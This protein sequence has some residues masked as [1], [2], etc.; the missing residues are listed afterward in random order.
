MTNMNYLFSI[1]QNDLTLSYYIGTGGFIVLLIILFA[2][3]CY[4]KKSIT[5]KFPEHFFMQ[6]GYL[7]S[8]IPALKKIVSTTK[9]IVYIDFSSVQGMTEGSYMTLLAQVEK[10]YM[11][12]ANKTIRISLNLPRSKEV[13]NILVKQKKYKHTNIKLTSDVI[14]KA[15]NK[16]KLTSADI[17]HAEVNQIID[18]DYADATVLELKSIGIKDYY[19][20]FYDFLIEVIGNASEHGLLNKNINWWMLKYKDQSRKCMTYVFVDMGLGI[21]ESYRRSGLL[22]RYSLRDKKKIPLD[23]L[24][25]K[26]G[27]STKKDG[28]GRGLPQIREAVE[29]GIVSDF[30]LI[31]NSVSLHY[32][33]SKFVVTTNPNFIGTYFSWTINKENYLTWKNSQ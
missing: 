13:I 8:V 28:R 22:K 33:D 31:T 26:L 30:V 12:N 14:N 29:K 10:A 25:G 3:Y 16:V 20:P 15:I 17:P 5:I 24:Y 32:I 6:Q 21:I 11:K 9:N 1:F 2:T 19:Q 27:S 23:A 18:T 4:T 7:K